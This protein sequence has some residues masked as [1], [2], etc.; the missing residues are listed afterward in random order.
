MLDVH[1]ES[2]SVQAAPSSPAAGGGGFC[3]L[4][5]ATTLLS[6]SL[7]VQ[8]PLVP[9]LETPRSAVD[10]SGTLSLKHRKNKPRVLQNVRYE[11]PTGER[12]FTFDAVFFRHI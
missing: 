12:S 2:S 10:E 5:K 7:A 11:G 8:L 9:S 6:K 4:Q 3:V 1:W